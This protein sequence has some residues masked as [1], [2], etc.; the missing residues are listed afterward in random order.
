[1]NTHERS[2]PMIFQSGRHEC[3]LACLAMV[4]DYYGIPIQSISIEGTETPLTATRVVNLAKS[5]GLTIRMLAVQPKLL[6]AITVP[7]IHHW[8]IGHFVVL[9]HIEDGIYRI[10]DPALGVLYFD[11]AA[12]AR[13]YSGIALEPS[14]PKA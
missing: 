4:S 7:S 2:V 12:L 3:A 10:H 5:I 1:M 14:I 6:P 9:A 13:R 11:E 8:T